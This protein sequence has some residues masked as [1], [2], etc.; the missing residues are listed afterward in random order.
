MSQIWNS[1][2]EG[3]G[4]I[5]QTFH[6]FMEPV[7]GTFAWGWAI[8]LLTFFVRL[9]LVPL[10]VKQT[11]SMRA[12]QRLQPQVK[13]IQAKYKVDRA[14]MRTDPQRYKEMKQKQQEETMK[15]Y[16]EAGANPAAGCLPLILQ[17]P[18]FIAL[19]NVLRNPPE[20]AAA[21]SAAPWYGI[22]QLQ[23]AP[24]PVG[25]LPAAGW[26]AWVLIVLMVATAF[27]SQKQMMSRQ[28]ATTD[29][30]ASQ[31]KILLYF[32][33][34]MLAFFS[35]N[36][37]SGVL[38][39]WVAT[40]VWTMG[41]QWVIFRRVDE[42]VPPPPDNEPQPGRPK[43]S[44]QRAGTGKAPAKPQSGTKP[45][46]TPKAGTTKPAGAPKT[47]ASKP[48]GT[49]KP[50][51]ASRPDASKAP[52]QTKPPRP[53]KPSSTGGNG[54]PAKPRGGGDPASNGEPDLKVNGSELRDPATGRRSKRTRE[55]E[56]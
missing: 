40:N 33:P 8:I 37:P 26:G 7:F 15:V 4:S 27:Y 54:Q 31:Q 29:Q 49:T 18:I 2:L 56:A 23:Y 51:G 10:A 36:F 17:M 47:G 1:L 42:T 35:L 28:V 20:A 16:Q 41:Q 12:M 13:K 14:L 55:D 46:G 6:S 24:R 45:A 39:Y 50:P 11:R 43:G 9:L 44:A 22:E 52:G 48:P 32:M 25:E 38:I 53:T 30:M 19:F 21:M 34:A 3:L 5:L